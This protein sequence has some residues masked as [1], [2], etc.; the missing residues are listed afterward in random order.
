MLIQDQGC[1]ASHEHPAEGRLHTHTYTRKHAKS[2]L[3]APPVVTG[4]VSAYA[5]AGASAHVGL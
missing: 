4:A 3:S 2:C 5:V 1:F